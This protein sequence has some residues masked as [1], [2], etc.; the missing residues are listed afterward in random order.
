MKGC[1]VPCTPYPPMGPPPVQLHPAWAASGVCASEWVSAPREEAGHVV[2]PESCWLHLS[3]PA[4]S[5][6]LTKLPAWPSS[7]QA[8]PA[9]HPRPGLQREEETAWGRGHVLHARESPVSTEPGQPGRAPR[10]HEGRARAACRTPRAEAPGFAGGRSWKGE[11]G[12]REPGRTGPTAGTGGARP[13][14]WEG[15][16]PHGAGA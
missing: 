6:P 5:P 2:R 16:D 8:E 12:P 10:S 1:W 15:A 4:C 9:R 7:L 13:D 3:C 11:P 14:V